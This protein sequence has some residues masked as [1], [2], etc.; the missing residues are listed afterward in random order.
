[1]KTKDMYMG[2]SGPVLHPYCLGQA[3]GDLRESV[4]RCRIEEFPNVAAI[5]GSSRL[6]S[7]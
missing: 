3:R 2:S 6:E 7:L 1:M 5:V 4:D